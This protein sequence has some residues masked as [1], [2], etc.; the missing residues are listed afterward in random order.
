MANL[1]GNIATPTL[2]TG[3]TD[4]S[5]VVDAY[6]S[7]TIE[8]KAQNLI[9]SALN[10]TNG[11]ILETSKNALVKVIDSK[12]FYNDLGTMINKFA[13]G[14]FTKDSFNSALGDWKKGA[15]G[16]IL[17][18]NGVSDLEGLKKNLLGSVET[19]VKDFAF[20][21]V[22]G[23]V[24]TLQPG[25]LDSVGVKSFSDAKKI[26]DAIDHDVRAIADMNT[27]AW[28]DASTPFVLGLS[29]VTLQASV[30]IINSTL[31]TESKPI[32][33]N[34]TDREIDNAILTGVSRDIISED[35]PILNDFL[36][37]NF[38]DLSN[39]AN[40]AKAE[41]FVSTTVS[42]AAS[43]GSIDYLIKAANTTSTSFVRSNITSP[44]EDFLA[45][46]SFNN[47]FT[48]ETERQQNEDLII[49]ALEIVTG[50]NRDDVNLETLKGLSSDAQ[51]VLKYSPTYGSTIAISQTLEDYT[52]GTFMSAFPDYIIS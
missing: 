39:E 21:G 20:G 47:K 40:M 44:V 24:D 1:P 6:D 42:D 25:L 49:N 43:N 8:S 34:S 10:L 46:I 18:A 38:G 12:R 17:Q 2:V 33:I 51:E 45:A 15:L 28:I 13:K 14:G 5:Q 41:L 3:K 35:S 37:T 27:E 36:F 19:N 26:Y 52:T 4:K 23:F 31:G 11:T 30:D 22:K 50:F 16:T 48:N 9:N 29:T 32:T 7:S